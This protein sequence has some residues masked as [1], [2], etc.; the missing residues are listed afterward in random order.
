MTSSAYDVH[1]PR[2]ADDTHARVR[3]V[4]TVT[5][6]HQPLT[7]V[8]PPVPV[9]ATGL[10]LLGALLL[11]FV[12]FTG[13]ISHVVHA[14]AQSL[15]YADLREELANGTAP[16]GAVD[17]NGLAL[18]PGAPV[19]LLEIPSLG[20]R[21]VVLEGTT[22]GVLRSGPGHRRD[23]VLP[24]QAGTAVIF[25]RRAAFG[26]PFASLTELRSGRTL[27]VTTG[28]GRHEYRITGTRRGGSAAPAPP[29]VGAGRL[30][31]VT[32]TGLPYLPEAVVR[33]DAELLSPV[34][35]T[36]PRVAISLA[37]AEQALA[38]DRS[39]LFLLVLWAQALLL[40]AC[41][42]V[43]LRVRWGLRQAWLVAVPVLVLL[44]VGASSAAVQ[45]LPNLL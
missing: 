14:R 45:L 33:V 28:Q 31:L 5:Q 34:Q 35:P 19:A 15:A 18:A 3:E 6:V 12:V 17:V 29:A 2:P 24:G 23:T 10:L 40:A 27:T 4:V 8:R 37:R 7:A 11:G 39:G 1:R 42:A 26:A 22:S 25:G 43:W 16:V 13:G 38:G 20:V 36:P 41:G 30:T 32:A 9:V 21:E 44:G